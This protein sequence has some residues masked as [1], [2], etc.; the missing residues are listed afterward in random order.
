MIKLF[1]ILLLITG[2]SHAQSHF[3]IKI[4]EKDGGTIQNGYTQYANDTLNKG[5]NYQ[6][7]VHPNPSLPSDYLFGGN[8][9]I[10]EIPAT[11]VLYIYKS[12]LNGVFSVNLFY[13]HNGIETL[14]QSAPIIQPLS[15][16]QVYPT[17][18]KNVISG[19]F[20]NVVLCTPSYYWTNDTI[21]ISGYFKGIEIQ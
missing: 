6:I 15:K 21:T 16:V 14:Y 17:P 13:Y 20:K 3:A 12:L 7:I 11:I 9:K 4:Y 19:E 18:N 10:T 8:T 5:S 1:W 2:V